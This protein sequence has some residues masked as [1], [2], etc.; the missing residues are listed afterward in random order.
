MENISQRIKVI[1]DNEGIKI[2]QLESKIGASKGVLSRSLANSTDIQSKWVTLVVEN[3]PKYSAEWLLTGKGSML[4]SETAIDCQA[5]H[6][7]DKLIESLTEENESLGHHIDLLLNSG[8]PKDNRTELEMIRQLAE[9][10]GK[11]KKEIEDL[12]NQGRGQRS[13]THGPATVKR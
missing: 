8:P 1:A 10:N 3:Y 12:K 9:E 5:C 7:K 13:I 4:K 11:L 2:T 6:E